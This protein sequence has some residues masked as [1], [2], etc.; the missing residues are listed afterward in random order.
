MYTCG[1]TRVNVRGLPV[2]VDPYDPE[3]VAVYRLFNRWGA[4]LYVGIAADPKNRLLQHE[5][6]KDW[7]CYVFSR[8]ITWY[9]NRVEA[10]LEESRAIVQEMPAFNIAGAQPPPRVTAAELVKG[11][12]PTAA[13][14]NLFF[15]RRMCEWSLCS[16]PDERREYGH[17]VRK[18][19]YLLLGR[20]RKWAKIDHANFV[21]LWHEDQDRRR[22]QEVQVR[23]EF[24]ERIE[25]R[26]EAE[27]LRM[28]RSWDARRKE[29]KRA[30][31]QAAA[32][33]RKAAQ[34][35]AKARREAAA[36]AKLVKRANAAD[37]KRV[38]RA[39][40]NEGAVQKIRQRHANGE[41]PQDLAKY[42][43]VS[44][45]NIKAV[46]ARRTWKH[47]PDLPRKEEASDVA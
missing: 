40:L 46:V 42:Y 25:Q 12:R 43:G 37:V 47:V 10:A 13:T 20:A 17:E 15:H 29:Q 31:K 44:S 5:V 14:L 1:V 6:E 8:T 18:A 39:I 23:T 4:L 27:R 19:Y 24:C 36:H 38:Y 21:R 28:K 34:A 41:S 11:Q 16:I 3:S 45:E 2:E 35:R 22:E 32:D 30:E 33:E 9:P 26:A 7:W